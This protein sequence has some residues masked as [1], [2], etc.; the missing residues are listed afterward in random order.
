MYKKEKEKSLFFSLYDD[1]DSLFSY[2]LYS[3]GFPRILFLFFFLFFFTGLLVDWAPECT[4]KWTHIVRDCLSLYPFI[5]HFPPENNEKTPLLKEPKL[6]TRLT[7]SHQRL[8]CDASSCSILNTLVHTHSRQMDGKIFTHITDCS[9]ATYRRI[10]R[11]LIHL[12]VISSLGYIAAH[13]TAKYYINLY[14]QACN[15][16]I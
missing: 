1:F 13:L 7:D 6:Y 9:M 11:A 5:F 12:Y 10:H 8:T 16:Q 15:T 4:R 14:I 3:V 2:L